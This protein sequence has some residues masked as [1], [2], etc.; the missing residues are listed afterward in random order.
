MTTFEEKVVIYAPFARDGQSLLHLLNGRG[1]NALLVSSLD[2]LVGHLDDNLGAVL[3]T[4][5]ALVQANWDS[6]L[7]AVRNQP[8]W[9]SYP[10]ILLIGQHRT[11]GQSDAVYSLF[12]PEVGNVMVLERPMSSTALLSALRWVIGGRLR[13]FITRD[14]LQELERNARHQKLL[15]RELA[16]RVKNTIAVLQSIVTQTMRPHSDMTNVRDLI[17]SRFS[18]LSRTHD[19]LLGTDFASANFLE[20]V[21]RTL[22]VHDRRFVA[23]GPAIEVSP[24]AA[25]SFALVLNE[26][27]TNAI[28]YGA[29]SPEAQSGT[30]TLTWSVDGDTF[31]FDWIERG[32]PKVEAPTSTGFGSR[33]IGTT[34]GALGEVDID[35]AEQGLTLQFSGPLAELTQSVV[36]LGTQNE[37]PLSL[38]TTH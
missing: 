13:Q 5:E 11:A 31:A 8:S 22:S 3:M 23:D 36:P 2:E 21:D 16:H 18:A 30:V 25:L 37:S 14:H 26:L 29:F 28:K 12:P 7:T 20:L 6:L 32:G 4:E 33:L 17:I 19:L 27:A 24:Q 1:H 15:T 35:Y 9:S 10:F 34:L 38:S